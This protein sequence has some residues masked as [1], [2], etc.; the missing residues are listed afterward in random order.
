ME[1]YV[2]GAD[3][4]FSKGFYALRPGRFSAAFHYNGQMN[5]H[6]SPA[7]LDAIRTRQQSL[8]PRIQQLPPAGSRPLTIA[9]RV[10]GWITPRATEALEGMDGVRVTDEAVHVVAA[11]RRRLPLDTIMA[12]IAQV[13]HRNGCLRGWR[14]ELLDVYGEGRRLCVLE[15]A[16]MRP[17]GLLTKAV[18][19]NAWSPDG[20]IWLARRADTKATDPGMWDTLVGGL[21][22]SAE[23]LDTSLLRECAE[24]AGLNPADVHDRSPLRI[25]LRMHRRLP[26]GYQVEDVL[27]SDCILPESVVPQNQDGEVSEIRLASVE[28]TWSMLEAGLFTHEAEACILDSLV[29]QQEAKPFAA[30][31]SRRRK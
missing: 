23:P 18:H 13:L 15:R 9:G 10:A 6:S 22:V 31:H 24:E 30:P 29:F 5:F 12:A 14:D 27:V 21:A 28:E 19:L 25:I 2:A 3:R 17:L 11:P 7:F 4:A 26:E 16:A 1:C 20:R 8:A